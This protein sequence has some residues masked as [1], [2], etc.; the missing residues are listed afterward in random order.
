[1]LA[2]GLY[3]GLV[4]L[5]SIDF[6]YVFA[7]QKT[8]L[9]VDDSASV[10]KLISLSLK[11]QGFRVLTSSDGME[12]LEV[13]PS[14]KVDL[15]ITDLNMPNI[16]GFELIRVVRNTPEYN[17]LPIIILSSMASNEDIT[18]GIDLG[19]NSYL[20]KPFHKKRIQYEVAKYL[21]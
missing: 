16:D 21:S 20:V 12:A 9:A 1:M 2:V 15:L 5:Y 6:I 11:L 13:L 14:E 3:Q 17:D 18:K 10:R 4:Y 8:I 19:A 7:M